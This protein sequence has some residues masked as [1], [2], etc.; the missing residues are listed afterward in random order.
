MEFSI[1]NAQIS[2]SSSVYINT[3]TILENMW[4]ISSAAST[5]P[6]TD[7]PQTENIEELPM[8]VDPNPSVTEEDTT[9]E[10]LTME[11]PPEIDDVQS[12]RFKDA[13]WFSLIRKYTV[14]MGGMGGINSHVLYN[15][16]RMHPLY[17][18]ARDPDTVE[19]VNLAGQMFGEGDIGNSKTIAAKNITKYFSP[20]ASIIARQLSISENSSAA[21]NIFISGFDNMTARRNMYNIWKR[22]IEAQ[23]FI[24]GRL[25]AEEFQ[26]FCFTKKDILLQERYEKEYLFSDAE[27]DA[28]VCSYKQTTYAASMIGAVIANLVANFCTNAGDPFIERNL[29]FMISYD[30][31]MMMFKTEM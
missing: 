26:V 7:E 25:N 17:I 3:G 20:T 1:S 13:P 23:L 15:L 22:T 14:F 31:S 30:A 21:F 4:E 6:H 10:A 8:D 2:Q 28:T 9:S 16:A 27:A 18:E 19:S 12:M 29:P 11:N 24:D 5:T